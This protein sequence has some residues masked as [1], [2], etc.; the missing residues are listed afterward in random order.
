MLNIWIKASVSAMLSPPPIMPEIKAG[1]KW[2]NMLDTKWPISEVGIRISVYLNKLNST[3]SAA[4]GVTLYR[5]HMNPDPTNLTGMK[6]DGTRAIGFRENV[7]KAN[8]GSKTWS[9]YFSGKSWTTSYDFSNAKY[10][11]E[12]DII[13]IYT[14][15]NGV[16]FML[17]ILEA[18]W[19]K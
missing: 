15:A 14:N 11:K 8:L 13:A 9:T 7:L 16:N 6:P 4:G 1:V 18:D 2:Y 5:P 3:S 17:T 19:L 10:Q 12:V